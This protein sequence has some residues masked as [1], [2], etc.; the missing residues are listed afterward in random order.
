MADTMAEIRAQLQA[1]VGEPIVQYGFYMSKGSFTKLP[2]GATSGVTKMLGG[3]LRKKQAGDLSG[4]STGAA[5]F[6]MDNH[7]TALVL[8]ATSLYAIDT[9]TSMT[10][11]Q[12]SFGNVLGAWLRAELTINGT[13]RPR[14]GDVMLLNLDIKHE[15]TGQGGQLETMAYTNLGDPSWDCYRALTGA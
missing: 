7:Q 4:T 11:R 12:M 13:A 6:G 3:L 15:P 14:P 2:A 8:T 5:M 10:T 9:T 1:K